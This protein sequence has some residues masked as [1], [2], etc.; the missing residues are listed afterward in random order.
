MNLFPTLSEYLSTVP[1]P[2]LVSTP[3]L[4][5]S[6]K[7]WRLIVVSHDVTPFHENYHLYFW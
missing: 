6:H 2:T 1:S 7:E 3:L 5:D 4:N